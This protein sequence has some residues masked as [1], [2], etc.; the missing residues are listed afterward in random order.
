MLDIFAEEDLLKKATVLGE[1]VRQRFDAW[2]GQFELIGEVR[3]L[4]PMLALELVKDRETKEPA[5]DEA[6][7]LV[8]FCH[9]RGLI[10]LACG[11]F[12]NVIRT[13]MPL[14]IEDEQ[15][16]RGLAIMEEGLTALSK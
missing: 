3:G 4:G 5:A 10:L 9:Q 13:L 2:Q 12:G 16:E 11:N 6:K 15:L 1:K 14:V 7:G 8:E